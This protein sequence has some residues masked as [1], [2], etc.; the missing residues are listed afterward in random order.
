[1]QDLVTKSRLLDDL[2]MVAKVDVCLTAQ[3]HSLTTRY[4]ITTLMAGSSMGPQS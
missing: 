4:H 3:Q 1:M 2:G